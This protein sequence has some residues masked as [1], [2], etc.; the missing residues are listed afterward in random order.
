MKLKFALVGLLALGTIGLAPQPA[1]AIPNGLP[2]LT[3][4]RTSSQCSGS[5]TRGDVAGGGRTT[6]AR[7]AST[8]H[9]ASVGA[10]IIVAGTGGHGGKP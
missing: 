10:G 7:S 2:M 8:L 4:S 6:I 3:S 9:R 5:A 1:S